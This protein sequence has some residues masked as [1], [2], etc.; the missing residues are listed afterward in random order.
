[1]AYINGN[2]ILNTIVLINDYNDGYEQGKQDEYDKFWNLF[3]LEGRKRDYTGAFAE[4]NEKSWSSGFTPK[5]SIIATGNI[6]RM[7]FRFNYAGT[8]PIDL[9]EFC[10]NNN[11]ELTINTNYASDD[12]FYQAK[13]TRIPPITINK[14]YRTFYECSYLETIDGLN[15]LSAGECVKA[16]EK[17]TALKNVTFNG[18]IRCNGID[19]NE[20]KNLTVE[21]LLSLLNALKDYSA[22]AGNYTVTLGTTNLAKLSDEQKAIATAKGWL[23]E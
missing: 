13:I 20:C 11:I 6:Y 7:F 2:Q 10:Q 22:S 16:F 1:M 14:A 18:E 9:V 12:L 23:L 8:D 21:S 19:L 4:G 15:I 17:C 3:Q 5:Y